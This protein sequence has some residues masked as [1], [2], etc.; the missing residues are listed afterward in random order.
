ME[1]QEFTALILKSN[2]ENMQTKQEVEKFAKENNL[3]LKPYKDHD[4][5]FVWSLTYKDN[6][7]PSGF[8]GRA[9]TKVKYN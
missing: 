2:I 5:G 4:L 8:G 3:Y 9:L 6:R 1:Y 7:K